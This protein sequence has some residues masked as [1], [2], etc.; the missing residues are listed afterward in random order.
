MLY[1]L[2]SDL[3]LTASLLS[4]FQGYCFLGDKL[5]NLSSAHSSLVF[6]SG[7][8]RRQTIL[9]D[10]SHPIDNTASLVSVQ[11]PLRGI[12]LPCCRASQC[13]TLASFGD[14]ST[15]ACS[16]RRDMSLTPVAIC[17]RITEATGGPITLGG[18]VLQEIRPLLHFGA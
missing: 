5:E 6:S 13:S 8:T 2:P 17:Q 7:S 15:F 3:A 9:T 12:S 4:S 1:M 11:W 18:L 16:Q 10:T 14:M